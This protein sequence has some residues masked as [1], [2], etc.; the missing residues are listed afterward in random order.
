[1]SDAR[2]V[3]LLVVDD[4]DRNLAALTEVLASPAHE[5]ATV[6]SSADAL[7]LLAAEDFALILVSVELQGA[8][9]GFETAARIK[10]LDA[11]R[12]APIILLTSAT[13]EHAHVQRAYESGA[14]DLIARPVDPVVMR[15]KVA[16]FVDLAVARQQ[17]RGEA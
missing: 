1:M 10:A 14:V 8:S 12:R 17:A 4:D 7:R 2:K 11:A 9:D 6:G 15:A 13:Q 3:K 16:V 5:L